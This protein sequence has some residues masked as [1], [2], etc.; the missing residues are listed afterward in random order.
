MKSN[1]KGES[2]DADQSSS[3]DGS[4]NPLRATAPPPEA[5]SEVNE[6]G[7]PVTPENQLVH[8]PVPGEGALGVHE[9][10]V[11][12]LVRKAPGWPSPDITFLDLSPLLA[13]VRALRHCV[14]SL[15]AR[16]SAAGMSHV[17]GVEARGFTFGCAC[18]LNFPQPSILSSF[19]LGSSTIQ[20]IFA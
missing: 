8:P 5:F 18:T 15:A 6:D 20:N 17:A 10:Y 16:Y 7:A 14:D 4:N 2:F 19:L 9:P 13:D 11:R 12:S 1:L 3:M